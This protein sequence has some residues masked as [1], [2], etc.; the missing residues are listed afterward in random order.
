MNAKL[1]KVTTLLWKQ[2]S[3]RIISLW[4]VKNKC[5]FLFCVDAGG[6]FMFINVKSYGIILQE[7]LPDLK[8]YY[9]NSLDHGEQMHMNHVLKYYEQFVSLFPK[10]LGKFVYY[11]DEYLIKNP[12]NIY[13]MIQ[14]SNM[15]GLACIFPCFDLEWIYD[16]KYNIGS[17]L[18]TFHDDMNRKLE[19][20]SNNN[21]IDNS[22]SSK[23]PEN[24]LSDSTFEISEKNEEMLQLKNLYSNM[25]SYELK[26]K[27]DL[28]E[29]EDYSG[30]GYTQS[31]QQTQK[32]I[33]EKT[34]L[35]ERMKN[36]Q[37]LKQETVV[38]MVS[39]YLTINNKMS[40]YLF[41]K[42]EVDKKFINLESSLIEM[43]KKFTK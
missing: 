19:Y 32:K 4:C 12:N 5:N 38:N 25:N 33:Y 1:E 37:K 16:N 24:F 42:T 11:V 39:T 27:K 41:Y 28:K 13:K 18:L 2:C 6:N 31:V 43:Y 22:I 21:I 15:T 26:M 36:L 35:K 29:L 30:S 3:I 7:S 20:L 10:Y 17:E 40:T 8:I 14:Q 34:K 9:M 23:I